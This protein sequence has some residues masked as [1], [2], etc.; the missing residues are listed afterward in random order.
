M[1][2]N[3]TYFQFVFAVVLAAMAAFAVAL[4]EPKAAPSPLPA[5][6][7]R[8]APQWVVSSYGYPWGSAVYY[9]TPVTWSLPKMLWS[10]YHKIQKWNTTVKNARK[11]I[12]WKF[13]VIKIMVFVTVYCTSFSWLAIPHLYKCF[14]ER[15]H[16]NICCMQKGII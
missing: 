13:W 3:E 1:Y 6:I 15:L 14:V 5:P 4:P 11:T 16:F 12:K 7:P 2:V 9:W 8:A 10:L